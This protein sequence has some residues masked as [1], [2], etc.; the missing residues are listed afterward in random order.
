MKL[1]PEERAFNDAVAD[2]ADG[3]G[4]H[5]WIMFNAGAAHG[6]AQERERY[7]NVVRAADAMRNAGVDLMQTHCIPDSRMTDDE[8][9]ERMYEIFDGPLQR[10]YDAARAVATK[11]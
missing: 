9:V 10:A 4:D 1:T 11:V 2:C 8:V 3:L 7:A 6:I 5:Y